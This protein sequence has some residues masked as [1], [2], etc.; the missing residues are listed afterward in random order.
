MERA[1]QSETLV[2][3]GTELTGT[4]KATCRVVV[5]GSIEGQI[6]APAVT[7]S[8]TGTV[9]GKVKAEVVRSDGTL[10]GSIDADEV[11]LSGTVRRDT[12]I[13]ARKLEVKLAA[14][15]GKL[16][17]SFGECVLEVGEDPARAA[18]SAPA[19]SAN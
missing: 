7:V 19:V 12:S 17:I 11:Q 15:R 8:A 1:T 3:E 16:E 18:E 5:H 10:A 4:L 2:E 14:E 13:R 6:E 9:V